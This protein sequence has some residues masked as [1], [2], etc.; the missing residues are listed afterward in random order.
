[1]EILSLASSSAG[2]CYRISDTK[3]SLLLEAGIPIQKIKQGLDYKLS[4]IDGVL[5]SHSH[6]DHCKAIKDILKAGIGVYSSK[7]TFDV[8]GTILEHRSRAIEQ[9]KQFAIGSFIIRPFKTQHDC[10]GSLGFLIQSSLTGE[11]LV[12]ITDSYYCKYLFKGLNY[13]MVEANYAADILQANVAAG[14]LP[15]AQRAR[16]IQSHFS[17][18]HVKEFLKANDLSQVREIYLLHLSAGNSDAERFKR[19]VQEVTGKMVIVCEK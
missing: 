17:L 14:C 18:E 2:N 12:F 6:N 7:E 16:L 10:E 11:K 9:H 3:T 4:E 19:E 8:T 13:I 15:E 5:I 1:M